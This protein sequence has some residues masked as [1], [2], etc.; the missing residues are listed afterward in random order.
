M[1]LFVISTILSYSQDISVLDK[2]SNYGL[3]GVSVYAL[4]S[5]DTLQT[6]SDGEV[7]IDVFDNDAV[8]IFYMPYFQKGRYT[9][10]E[11]AEI[12]NVVYLN[13]GDALKKISSTSP[14]KSREYSA[15]LPFFIDIVDLDDESSLNLTDEGTGERITFTNNEGGMSVFRGLESGKMLLVID[16]IRLNNA[17]HRNGKVERLLNYDNTMTQRVQQIYGTGFTIYSPEATGGV[18]QYFTIITPLSQEY[19]FLYHIEAN[20]KYES[21]SNSSISNLSLSMAGLKFSSF[22]SVSYGNFGDI[23]MGKNRNGVPEVDSLYG[24]N[25]YYIE[26]QNDSDVVVTNK[27]PYTQVGTKYEQ[28]YVLQKLR[29]KVGDYSNLLFNFHYVNTSDVGIYSGLTEMNGDHLRFSECNFEPQNKFLTSINLLYERKTLIFDFLSIQQSFS[30]FNEY[31]VTRKYNNPVAL[32]QK[33][34]LFVSKFNVDFVKLF[35]I[36]RMLY[37][38]EYDFNKLESDAFFLNIENNAVSEGLNR[39]PSNGSFS[40][41]AAIYWNYKW[42]SHPQFVVNVGARYNFNF[43]SANFLNVSPQL[44]L[45]FTEK[46]YINSA[47]A[48]SVSFDTYPFRG[49][50]VKMMLSTAQHVPIIDDFGKIMV[51][52]FIVNIPTDNLKS[53][54]LVSGELGITTTMFEKIRIFGSVF[55]TK[56]FD[57]IISK[58]TTLNGN[59]SLY[60]GS[61]RYNIATKVNVSQA[62]IY[63]VSGGFNFNYSFDEHDRIYFKLGTS[64]NYVKGINQQDNISLPNISPFYGNA[65]LI[66]NL[67]SASLR[68]SYVFNGLKPY[69]ELSLVG[70]DYIEKAASVGFLSWNTFNAKFSFSIMNSVK[71]TFGV[72]NIFDKFYRQYRTAVVA[73]GRNFIF[74][75]NFAIK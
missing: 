23:K 35:N 33:E 2:F 46:I 75:V 66:F 57:A 50:Q 4:N 1:F 40:H 18:V 15:D 22:T 44:P 62:Y 20:S 10:D 19:S 68:L 3:A 32:H 72:D 12:H 42:M 61:D 37:G 48:A 28:L 65:N 17:I 29:F 69:D 21:A 16:G 11:L 63:G 31:R 58:D 67:Y 53:E 71:L 8:I 6:N 51:K 55:Y 49:L 34:N 70:E 9:K 73:P 5:T 13:R 30:Y 45:S 52:D 24:L 26:R 56:M 47:P 74:S 25:L 64:F 41:D 59:D 7:N 38:L 43:T 14:L 27:D 39:Y 60:F 36:N 54:K